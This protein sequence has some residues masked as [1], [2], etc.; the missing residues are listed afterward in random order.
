VAATP[1]VVLNLRMQIRPGPDAN[2]PVAGIFAHVFGGG[3]GPG[4]RL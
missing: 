1:F 2:R 4:D 3:F